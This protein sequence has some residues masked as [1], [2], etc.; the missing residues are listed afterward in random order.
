MK[1][2]NLVE[3]IIQVCSLLTLFGV[4]NNCSFSKKACKLAVKR[5]SDVAGLFPSKF[6]VARSGVKFGC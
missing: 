6:G 3:I 1:L 4:E 5:R 2:P